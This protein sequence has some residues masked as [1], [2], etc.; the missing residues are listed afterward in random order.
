MKNDKT[1][2]ICVTIKNRGIV[3]YKSNEDLTPHE[4]QTCV[5]HDNVLSNVSDI[6]RGLKFLNKER[7]KKPF[8]LFKEFLQSLNRNCEI[9]DYKG[10]RLELIVSDWQSSD[11]DVEKE[12]KNNWNFFYQ[13]IPI[14]DVEC[15]KGFSRGYGL[16]ECVKNSSYDVIH[17]T[18]V[19]I[20]YTSP[21]DLEDGVKYCRDGKCYFPIVYKEQSPTALTLYGEVAGE[22]ISFVKKKHFDLVGGFPDY[23]Q[24]GKEDNDLGEGLRDLIGTENYVRKQSFLIH[25]WHSDLLR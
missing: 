10:Y 9:L 7:I 25:K 17:F 11:I 8:F 23:R 3:E 16:N 21:F 6:Q 15:E 2:S 24:W 22:G 14:S 18:D 13:Y 5:H 12:I 20:V 1:L 4:I 19:D